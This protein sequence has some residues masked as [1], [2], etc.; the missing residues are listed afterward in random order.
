MQ[1]GGLLHAGYLPQPGV[2]DTSNAGGVVPVVNGLIS[3]ISWPFSFSRQS[4]PQ[5]D[6]FTIGV[7]LPVN[8]S[9]VERFSLFANGIFP[10]GKNSSLYWTANYDEITSSS[11]FFEHRTGV[12]DFVMGADFLFDLGI[13]TT[14][15]RF[16]AINVLFN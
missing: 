12:V 3:G 7:Y 5:D 14:V 9:V 4:R 8:S 15:S 6:F 11:I 1:Q 10:V 2:I 16:V 13:Q